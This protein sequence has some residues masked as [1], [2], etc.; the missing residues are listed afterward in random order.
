MIEIEPLATC[1]FRMFLA[2]A[3]EYGIQN[4]I[5]S[6]DRMDILHEQILAIS[7]KLITVKTRD[8]SSKYEIENWV[9]NAFCLISLGLEY[10]IKGDLIKAA[11]LLN[12]NDLIKF[13]QIGNTLTKRLTK[14]TKKV[15]EDAVLVSPDIDQIEVIREEIK[16]YNTYEEQ[17]FE[18]LMSLQLNIDRA[19]IVLDFS[20]TL[21]PITAMNDL[22]IAN[23]MLRNLE[24]RSE[25]YRT[26]PQS[27]IFDADFTSLEDEDV[28]GIAITQALMINLA[29]YRQLEFHVNQEDIGN[30]HDICYD[31]KSNT[32]N[33][34]TVDLLIGWIGHFLDKAGKTE[35]VKRYT[36]QYWRYC[37]DKLEKVF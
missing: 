12:R 2:Q 13:F 4:D 10:A 33:K 29:L 15:R 36:I 27:K 23:S 37:L 3:F 35:Q 17:L 19:D 8:S 28:S 20:E 30:F 21:R 6:F 9:T 24:L 16:I 32:I 18:A 5:I 1:D 7:N 26:L 34:A 22:N 11:K 14:Y 31:K 25:Y